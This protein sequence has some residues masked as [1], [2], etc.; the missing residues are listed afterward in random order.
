MNSDAEVAWRWF[1]PKASEVYS[2]AGA[3]TVALNIGTPLAVV[4]W[5]LIGA[6]RG[7]WGVDENFVSRWRWRM[8]F[9]ALIVGLAVFWLLP[10]V[11]II[12]S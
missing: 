8:I 3:A 4:G 1:S 2:Y 5:L 12:T 10:K 11:E 7:G 6:S 9:A